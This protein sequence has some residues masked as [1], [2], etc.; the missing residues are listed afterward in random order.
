LQE[1]FLKFKSRIKFRE[2]LNILITSK[3]QFQA[4][5]A[6]F[7]TTYKS[8]QL[9]DL[10]N[11][12][13]QHLENF[14]FSI[15]SL[16]ELHL[17]GNELSH[18][19]TNAF[20]GARNLKV[21]DLSFNQISIIDPKIFGSLHSLSDLNLSHN[22]LS[23]IS[24]S[25][26]ENFGID[27]TI[28]SLKVLDLSHNLIYYYNVMPYQSFSGLRNLETL[29]LNHN[30]ITF[31]YGAFASNQKLKTLDFSYNFFASFELDFLLSL[32]TLENLYLSGNGIS[33]ASQ[34]DLSD[35]RAIFPALKSIALTE[36]TFACEVLASMIRKLDK[37]GIELIVD[38]EKFV[39]D[40]RNLRG[41]QCN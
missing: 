16:I 1:K 14:T 5:P 11:S 24:F 22:K 25:A 28:E 18:L 26:Q 41:V 12:R 3:S 38:E 40:A 4:L 9:I 2:K 20:D 39:R 23:N 37:A 34:I 32:R 7:F 36:N 29:K 35:V 33:Y 19:L 6:G 10:S 30:N 15:E 31:D 8:L 17:R 21:L 27:W 13:L